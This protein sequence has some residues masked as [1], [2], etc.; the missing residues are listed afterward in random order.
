[1]IDRFQYQKAVEKASAML[2]EAGLA[3][4]PAERER[5][6][7]AD[8]GLNELEKTGL[9]IITYVNTDR[10]CAK[11]I[12][13][14]PVKPVRSINIQRLVVFPARK[15]RFAAVGEPFIS[16]CL[17]RHPLLSRA[18]HLPGRSLTTRSIGKSA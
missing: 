5:F 3:I 6:E 7:V 14:T 15:K 18:F 11:E 8:F 2:Q 12:I 17:G 1:M 16:M 9:Q 4:T 10:C 13:M